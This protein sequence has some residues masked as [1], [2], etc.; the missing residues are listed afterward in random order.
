MTTWVVREHGR[1]PL[2]LP[3]EEVGALAAGLR[4]ADV[5]V[6][7]GSGGFE[8]VA[9]GRVGWVPVRTPSRQGIVVVVPK[10]APGRT[11]AEAV[12]RFFELALCAEGVVPRW[13]AERAGTAE[14]AIA[15]VWPL[16][17]GQLYTDA[18]ADL[19]RNDL[20]RGYVSREEVRVGSVV[21]AIDR[22][23]HAA[24]ALSGRAHH[25][26][27]R[28][29]EFEHDHL[30]NRVLKA[31]ARAVR[32]RLDGLRGVVADPRSLP[33]FPGWIEEALAPVSAHRPTAAELA[34]TRRGPRTHRY[35]RALGLA[36]LVLRAA[37]GE[38]RGELRGWSIASSDVFERFAARVVSGCGAHVVLRNTFEGSGRP[39]HLSRVRGRAANE[40]RPDMVV[41]HG[42][43]VLAVGD[44]KYKRV[45]EG[46]P[47]PSVDASVERLLA[48]GNAD[49]YQLFT[50]LRAACCPRGFFVVPFWDDRPGA[51]VVELSRD[52][53]FLVP[54]LDDGRVEVVALG[55]NGFAPV[56]A[57]LR[58]GAVA[59]AEWLEIS[60]GR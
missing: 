19:L 54:P 32:L 42:G 53:A 2:S 51:P 35:A 27:C 40:L 44:A 43:A 28:W 14:G 31:A 55:L 18:L 34:Q 50:Y 24:L 26:P 36:R 59:L 57:V 13:T 52:L 33:A 10:G 6:E 7:A 41:M 60:P 16:L 46:D 3:A 22:R 9:G 17:L 37:D 45:L 8:L 25:L 56:A 12:R 47:P 29:E 58:E 23:R 4:G 49:L 39:T 5:R 30:D 15:C 11:E 1:A 21:G 20:R 38:A 48:V